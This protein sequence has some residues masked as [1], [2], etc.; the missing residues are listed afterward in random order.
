MNR[1]RNARPPGQIRQGQVVSTFGPG[2][3]LDL[4]N[5]SVLVAGL[6]HWTGVSEE[7]VEPRLADKLCILLDVS[8]IKLY[9]PPPD[10]QDS[11]APR[12]GIAA[13]QFPEW[14][15]EQQASGTDDQSPVRSRMMLHRSALTG[16][17]FI[18][19]NKKRR[20]VVPIRFVPRL[21]LRT[22]R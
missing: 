4:P 20:A 6:E 14:F 8:S 15:I 18:D 22:H 9:A 12:N 7:I 5:Y 16:G 21:P 2:A 3:M 10:P 17:K 13:W 19:Q 11:T 1:Q